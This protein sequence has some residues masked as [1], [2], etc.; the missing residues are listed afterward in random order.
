MLS[1]SCAHLF[2]SAHFPSPAV[3][4]CAPV[5]VHWLCGG[6]GAE[7]GLLPRPGLGG[8]ARPTGPW[9]ELPLQQPVPLDSLEGA[10]SHLCGRTGPYCVLT[11]VLPPT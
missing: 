9:E 3:K 1:S 10:S 7:L 6:A 8:S 2:L 11:L 4:V 5:G